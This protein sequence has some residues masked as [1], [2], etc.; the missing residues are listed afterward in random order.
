M[1]ALAKGSIKGQA[2]SPLRQIAMH[3]VL[4]DI[5]LHCMWIPTK[6]NVLADALSRSETENIA[7]LCPSLH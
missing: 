6:E 2:I 1:V 4:Q 5:K 7:N 3:T